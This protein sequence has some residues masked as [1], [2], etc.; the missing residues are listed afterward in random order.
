MTA[1]ALILV[2]RGADAPDSPYGAGSQTV[3]IGHQVRA[4]VLALRPELD[5][6]VAFLDGGEPGPLPVASQLAKRG[7]EEAVVVSL[8]VSHAFGTENDLTGVAAQARAA[9][10]D[11]RL[12]V[13]RPVGPEAKLLSVVD[14]QLRAALRARRVGELDGLVFSAAGS[15]DPR[16]NALLARR[17]RQWAHHHR[18]PCVGAYGSGSGPS[19]TEAIRTLRGQG[20]RHIAVGSW[21]LAADQTY[22]RQAELAL[23]AG[24][25]A[26]AEPLGAGPEL[27]ET[28]LSRYLVAAIDL[29]ELDPLV[30]D[31][32]VRARHLSVVSA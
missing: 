30:A 19:M 6:A 14:R 20:R 32:P 3:Q 22:E 17:A 11:L 18:L 5:V 27:A 15:S 7:L 21:F 24:A 12:T 26:V 8:E 25:V 4:D 29:V 2:A 1:P 23:S 31:L 16:S 28:A 13:S 10:P 9:H